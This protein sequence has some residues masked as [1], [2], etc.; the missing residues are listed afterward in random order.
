MT[1]SLPFARD[2]ISNS[3]VNVGSGGPSFPRSLVFYN[4][5]NA[6]AY[7]QFFNSN[8]AGA[9]VG[10]PYWWIGLDAGGSVALDFL[11]KFP[12]GLSIA[13]ATAHDGSSALSSAVEVS[14]VY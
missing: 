2:D 12:N 3:A 1:G 6:R 5:A 8:A 14:M 9:T 13:A 10:S 7:L 4:P 11:P